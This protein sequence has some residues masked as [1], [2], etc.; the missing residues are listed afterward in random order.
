MRKSTVFN[1]MTD[2]QQKNAIK[3]RVERIHKAM[4]SAPADRICTLDE[5]IKKGSGSY[6]FPIMKQNKYLFYRY[7]EKKANGGRLS[8]PV[9]T[10]ER[11]DGSIGAEFFVPEVGRLTFPNGVKQP[12]YAMFEALNGYFDEIQNMKKGMSKEKLPGQN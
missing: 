3:K 8:N 9:T 6:V 1:S 7:D 12:T 4:D 10:Y 2:D 11:P 5:M